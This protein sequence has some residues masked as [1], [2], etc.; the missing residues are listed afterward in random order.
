[1]SEHERSLN[2]E[3]TPRVTLEQLGPG[4]LR[5]DLQ[6][7]SHITKTDA[8]LASAWVLAL[9]ESRPACVL[10]DLTGVGSVSKEAVKF[11]S[12]ASRV[13]A[14]ALLGRTAVDKVIAHSLRGLAWPSCPVRYFVD[15]VEAMAWLE[16]HC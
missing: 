14:F 9:A 16:G 3:P 12:K 4:I 6:P 1:M 8:E 7:Q 15:E 11:Y 5:I 10:L 2:A 13:A